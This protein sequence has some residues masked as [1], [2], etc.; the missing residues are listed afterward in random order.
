MKQGKEWC[1]LKLL[2]TVGAQDQWGTVGGST[3]PA[4]LSQLTQEEARALLPLPPCPAW[5][6]AASRSL[7]SPAVPA[8]PLFL[9]NL[10]PGPEESAEQG[11]HRPWSLESEVS[12]EA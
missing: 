7:N 1:V 3:K 8:H 9:P 4:S 5:A 11:D 10:L 12:V 2:T 6:R